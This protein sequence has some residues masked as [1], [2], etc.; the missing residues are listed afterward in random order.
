MQDPQQLHNIMAAILGFYALMYVFTA[1]VFIVP[2]WFISKKAGFTPWLSL[3]CVFPLTGVV[4]LYI[5]AF[6]EWKTAP[7]PV[8]QGGFPY[9]P[10]PPR[11]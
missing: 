9:P 10:A 11:L 7:V 8:T 5:L 4:L 2:T 1:V 6:A 3:L